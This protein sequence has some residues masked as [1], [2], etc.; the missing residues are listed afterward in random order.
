MNEKGVTTVQR[1][2]KIVAHKE[3]KHVGAVTS[4]EHGNLL[5]LAVTINIRGCSHT[6]IFRI[7]LMEISRSRDT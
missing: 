5:T 4:A 2:N 3:I 6:S 1:P 7:S